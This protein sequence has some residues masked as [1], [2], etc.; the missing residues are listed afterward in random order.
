MSV[1][2][3]LKAEP[4]VYKGLSYINGCL[5]ELLELITSIT[6]M[7]APSHQ[8][9]QRGALVE[10]VMKD[11]GFPSV[12]TDAVGN[13]IGF[14]PGKD[15]SRVIVSLAHMDTVFPEDTDLTVRRE[16][17]ILRA[18]GI[19][20]NSASVA[21]M[22][23]LGK[24]FLTYGQLPH[25]VILVANVGE[26]GLGDLKGARYFCEHVEHYDFGG[27]RLS[28]EKLVFLN[29]DGNIDYITT[30]GIGSR[31][32][33][34]KFTGE[35]GHSWGAF[36]KSSAIHGAAT[37]IAQIYS[38][39]VPDKPK[40]TYNVGVISGGHSVNSIAQE[41]EMLIDMRS[42]KSEPLAK[43][44]EAVLA[45]LEDAAKTTNT[46]YKIEVVGD[47]PTGS[48]PRDSQYAKGLIELGEEM[49]IELIECAS[50]TDSN[51]PLSKGWPS[52]TMGF[53]RSE[54][55][56]RVSEYLYIDSLI[57]G[58]KFALFCFAGRL[59]DKF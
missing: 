19:S 57:P 23:I 49:G 39:K 32:L 6:E 2:Q 58:L 47:R 21:Q 20:D 16:G 9:A 38:I 51:I 44:E 37:A 29:I 12:Q 55:G 50:S 10:K 22:L 31:R 54:N 41:A 56:H 27:L 3:D 30:A 45:I 52:V 36:G 35:G 46:S 25:P 59:Y 13:V 4:L 15:D 1:Y 14:I 17:N 34:V 40:T 18:P 33:K 28:P 48:L 24:I 43:L 42:E 7:P 26:E 53:K 11:F 8:E 5:E